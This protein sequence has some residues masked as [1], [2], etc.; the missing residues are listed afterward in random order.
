LKERGEWIRY[1]KLYNKLKFSPNYR[2]LPAQTAQQALRLIDKAWRSFFRAIREWKK[3]PEKF[4]KKPG[5]PK[6]K[7]KNGEHL[8]VFTNQQCRIKSSLVKFPEKFSLD[9]DIKT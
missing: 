3:N 7:K 8:L 5:P 2:Q 9:F 1:N 6:Y 4:K